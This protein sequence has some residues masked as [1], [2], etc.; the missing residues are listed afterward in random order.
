M[1]RK[2]EN[3]AKENSFVTWDFRSIKQA[4]LNVLG[5]EQICCGKTVGTAAKLADLSWFV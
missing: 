1:R 4:L 2:Q 3:L 5:L